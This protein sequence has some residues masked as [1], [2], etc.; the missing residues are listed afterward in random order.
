MSNAWATVVASIIGVTGSVLLFF[1]SKLRKEN[2][3]DHAAVM[4]SV[5]ILHDDMKAISHKLDNHIDWH[6]KK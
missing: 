4:Q 3:T 1:L 6:L 2:K 5:S